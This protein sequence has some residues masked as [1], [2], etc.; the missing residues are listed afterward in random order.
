MLP[1]GTSSQKIVFSDK[2]ELDEFCLILDSKIDTRT[3]AA[4]KSNQ[5]KNTALGEVMTDRVSNL[6]Y[7][8][9]NEKLKYEVSL[10]P[11]SP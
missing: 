7:A 8:I 3:A 11:K 1:D 10:P 9:F 2:K 4:L 5:A 6:A